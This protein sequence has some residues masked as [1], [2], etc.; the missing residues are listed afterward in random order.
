VLPPFAKED[1]LIVPL[2][3]PEKAMGH[4]SPIEPWLALTTVLLVGLQTDRLRCIKVTK[5]A[6]NVSV[7]F[8][9]S[10]RSVCR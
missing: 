2:G 7:R 3:Q 6:G 4:E 10:V 1:A 9:P 8:E 5:T